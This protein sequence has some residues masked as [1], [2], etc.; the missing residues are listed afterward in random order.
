MAVAESYEASPI[1][2]R[3]PAPTLERVAFKTSRLAEFCGERELTAQTGHPKQEWPLVILKELVDNA[4]DEA[5]EAQIAPEIG[6]EVSTERGEIIVTDNGRGLPSETIKGMLDYSVRVSSREAYVSPSRGQQGNALKCVVAMGFALDGH[7]GLTIIE[8]HGEAHRVTF[9]MDP[10]HRV[11]V[12]RLEVAP[13]LV[14]NGTRITVR[15]PAIEAVKRRFVQMACAF[16]TFKPA[17]DPA[18]DLG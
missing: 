3:R 14:Q 8:S 12:I 9:E 2:P 16:T 1:N 11:P 15:W 18:R 17:P 10:V 13:S 7:H 5:E 6:I 4:L